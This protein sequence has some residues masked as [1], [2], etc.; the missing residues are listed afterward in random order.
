MRY[1]QYCI[2]PLD[3]TCQ[4]LK[5][6]TYYVNLTPTK[7]GGTA[8]KLGVRKGIHTKTGSRRVLLLLSLP[9]LRKNPRQLTYL[10][11]YSKYQPR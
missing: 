6:N 4:C 9:L 3:A 5:Y 8:R 10:C 1:E 2:V 7:R 11:E